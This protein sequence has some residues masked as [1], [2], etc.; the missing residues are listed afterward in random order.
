[1]Q[2][3]RTDNPDPHQPAERPCPGMQ[4]LQ[5]MPGGEAD[6]AHL[7]ISSRKEIEIRD[8]AIPE[9]PEAQFR[10]ANGVRILP[11]EYPLHSAVAQP[12]QRLAYIAQDRRG[13]RQAAIGLLRGADAVVDRV[14]TREARPIVI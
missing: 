10:I 6:V 3:E 8:V 4:D 9:Q 5:L 11:A 13:R 7:R 14:E 12:K 2:V 1:M